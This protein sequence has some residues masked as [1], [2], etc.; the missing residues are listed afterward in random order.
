MAS[1]EGDAVPAAPLLAAVNAAVTRVNALPLSEAR[2]QQTTAQRMS[3]SARA[4][5][6]EDVN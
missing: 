4:G 2:E 5:A 6:H 1:G 3:R